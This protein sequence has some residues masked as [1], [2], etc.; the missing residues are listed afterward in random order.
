MPA[1]TRPPPKPGKLGPPFDAPRPSW[2]T[3]SLMPALPLWQAVALTCGIDPDRFAEAVTPILA[4]SNPDDFD[5]LDA[6]AAIRVWTGQ[7]PEPLVELKRRL[8]IAEANHGPTFTG[9]FET[10]DQVYDRGTRMDQFAPWVRGVTGWEVPEGFP[11]WGPKSAAS[12]ARQ[13]APRPAGIFPNGPRDTL[14]GP[15]PA[16]P[17]WTKW[18]SISQPLLW[19]A[20]ALSCNFEPNHDVWRAVD[21]PGRYPRTHPFGEFAWRWAIAVRGYKAREIPSAGGISLRQE[22]PDEWQTS[23]EGFG[24]WARQQAALARQDKKTPDQPAISATDEAEVGQIEWELPAE[25]PVG[26]IVRGPSAEEAHLWERSP[27]LRLMRAAIREMLGDYDSGRP[28]PEKKK[29]VIWFKEH[30]VPDPDASAL[31]R[32]LLG[33]GAMTKKQRENWVSTLAATMKP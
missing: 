9:I 4:V 14:L 20:V 1:R 32:V 8:K 31:A 22:R 24:R 11:T 16:P 30:G 5:G 17:D 19:E 29:I 7:L 33:T 27:T 3:W 12:V 21:S 18:R 25:F 2:E 26:P 13:N 28:M 6:V 15:V 10:S 23:M